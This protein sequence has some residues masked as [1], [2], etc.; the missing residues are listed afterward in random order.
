MLEKGCDNTEHSIIFSEAL[1][2]YRKTI[3]EDE[4]A[5]KDTAV[6]TR[7]AMAAF[8]CNKYKLVWETVDM[9]IEL[10]PTRRESYLLKAGLLF[11]MEY[12]PDAIQVLLL[13]IH[14]LGGDVLLEE[15]LDLLEDI[16]S[17]TNSEFV[18]PV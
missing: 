2:C 17:C 1:E 18:V 5:A 10:S 12:H 16:Q 11:H 7:L 9:V 15:C 3:S 6:L 13:G 14:N 4:D 8:H